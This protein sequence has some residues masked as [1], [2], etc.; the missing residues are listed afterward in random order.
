M[1]RK[2]NK[3]EIRVTPIEA[4]AILLVVS[5]PMGGTTDRFGT[6]RYNFRNRYDDICDEEENFE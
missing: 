5:T 2:Y 3:P 6:R 4:D 1:K